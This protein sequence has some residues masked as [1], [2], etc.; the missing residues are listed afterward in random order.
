MKYTVQMCVLNNPRDIWMRNL[1]VYAVQEILCE[2]S[3]TLVPADDGGTVPMY[4]HFWD[5]TRLF[6]YQGDHLIPGQFV[7]DG[8]F[9]EVS[10]E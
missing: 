10:H 3:A 7:R 8:R 1:S 6:V 9:V 2:Y 4:E 5:G